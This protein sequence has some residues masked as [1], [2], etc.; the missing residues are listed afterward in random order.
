MGA[1]LGIDTSNYTTSVALYDADKNTV[2]S[3]KQ[4]LGVKDGELG[5]RQSDAVFKHTKQLHLLIEDAMSG[6]DGKITAVGVSTKPRN[7]EDS[8]MP[9]FLAGVSVA[10]SIA[11]V[12][13]VPIYEF[14]HQSGHIAA[15]LYSSDM[16][17]LIGKE[18]YAFH[19]SGGT[20][21]ALRVT[22]DEEDVFECE[23]LA[24]SLDLKMGQL[25][26]RTGVMLS[27]PFPSGMYLEE[28]AKNGASPIK[29][30]LSLK[31]MDCCLSGVQNTVEKLFQNG[32]K[33]ENIARY[34]IDYCS[35][36]IDKMI[37]L[38]INSYG[39]KPVVL[40]GGVMSNTI[41]KER[42]KTEY[43]AYFAEP[44][45]SSDNACGTAVLTSYKYNKE[46]TK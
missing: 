29:P 13:R 42:I 19:I 4:L 21:E 1:F 45:F 39:E 34:V 43:N 15:A 27:L 9:C 25:I 14:S 44:Q 7:R 38:L 11:A 8:Y 12:L 22:P 28:L 26:D 3:R 2:I 6:F 46:G 16:L 31:G 40:A 17:N 33:K 41:I 37:N 32:E 24:Q 18:F 23:L 36:V 35:E 20:T 30:K 5:L 10:K